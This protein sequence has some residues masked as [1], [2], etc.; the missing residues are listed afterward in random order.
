MDAYDSMAFVYT[1]TFDG[2]K[3]IVSSVRWSED[4]GYSYGLYGS[5]LLL[6]VKEKGNKILEL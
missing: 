4:I 6:T 3:G 1:S 5:F 2:Y